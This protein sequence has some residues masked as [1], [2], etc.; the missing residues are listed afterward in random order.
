M[1]ATAGCINQCVPSREHNASTHSCASL[2]GLT[3]QVHTPVHHL[4]L[5]D[6]SSESA[7]LLELFST[8]SVSKPQICFPFLHVRCYFPFRSESV[9]VPAGPGSGSGLQRPQQRW[10][11]ES[12]CRRLRAGVS[13]GR[14]LPACAVSQPDRVLLVLHAGRQAGQ[15]N[16]S[17]APD[18]QL[19]RSD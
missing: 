13:P 3:A 7:L 10:P 19:H 6:S 2:R 1:A 15:R 8:S 12:S 16:L 9:Q 18:P 11:R 17:P 5:T 14:S 4:S